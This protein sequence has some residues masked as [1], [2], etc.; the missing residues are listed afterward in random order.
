MTQEFAGTPDRI[1]LYA[2]LAR[3]F[4]YPDEAFWDRFEG[5]PLGDAL[6]VNLVDPIPPEMAAGVIGRRSQEERAAEYFATFE[7]G[8]PA[9]EGLCRPE[10]GRDGIFEDLLRF[11]HYFGLRLSERGRD[12]PDSFVTELEFMAYLV[13][14]EI[15][16]TARGIEVSSLQRA[17]RDFLSRHL[18][19]WTERACERFAER[20]IDN[21]YARL[22]A[23]SNALAKSHR[24]ALEHRLADDLVRPRASEAP[25]IRTGTAQ[26]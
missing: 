26:P 16:A 5:R 2:F 3:A 7:G 12:F 24:D 11:Y 8:V 6:G 9:Y 4:D 15:T 22:A 17:Q 19:A 10:E 23:W 21:A 13:R 20:G 1:D 25:A 18:T 14:L